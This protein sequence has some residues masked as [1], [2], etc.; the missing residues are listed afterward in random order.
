MVH[1]SELSVKEARK[2]AYE[3]KIVLE[4]DKKAHFEIVSDMTRQYKS[5][6][7]ELLKRISD[8]EEN[9]RK[10]HAEMGMEFVKW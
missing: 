3:M 10:H 8:L 1:E 4:D 7:E 6:R 5:M 9:A 2:Q